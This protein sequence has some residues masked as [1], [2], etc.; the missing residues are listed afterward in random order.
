MK[1]SHFQFHSSF[2]N[3]YTSLGAWSDVVLLDVDSNLPHLPWFSSERLR[4][5]NFVVVDACM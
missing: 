2:I 5:A 3:S 4:Q 1:S